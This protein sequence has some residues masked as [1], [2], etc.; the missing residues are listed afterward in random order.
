MFKR[1]IIKKNFLKIRMFN[2]G[3]SRSNL[4]SNNQ[5]RL[6]KIVKVSKILFNQKL[7]KNSLRHILTNRKNNNNSLK[8]IKYRK[9]KIIKVMI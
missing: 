7:I 9:N 8:L 5:T 3:S 6:Q 4:Q 2:S 1:K